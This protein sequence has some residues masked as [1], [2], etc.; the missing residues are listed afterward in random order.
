MLE[1][2]RTQAQGSFCL[3]T[4]NDTAVKSTPHRHGMLAEQSWWNVG[5]EEQRKSL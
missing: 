3:V 1:I 4:S 5:G 2:P